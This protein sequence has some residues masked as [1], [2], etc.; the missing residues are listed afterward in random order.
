MKKSILVTVLCLICVP[1]IKSQHT[2][3][4]VRWDFPVKFGTEEWNRLENIRELIDV[5][6]IPEAV[7]TVLSTEELAEICLRYPLLRFITYSNNYDESIENLLSQFNGARELF[8][9]NDA[10]N[11]LL[12][13]YQAKMHDLS[14]LKDMPLG[15]ER[16]FFVADIAAHEL[17]ISHCLFPEDQSQD[18]YRE[19]MQQLV[20]GYEE[21][22]RYSEAFEGEFNVNLFARIKILVKADPQ[23]LELIP[24]HENNAVFWKGVTDK[25]TEQIINKLTY[26]FILPQ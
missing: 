24:Q 21:K 15:V 1:I 14:F 2:D 17:L 26:R 16:G 7:L 8:K 5:C 25:Q 4:S 9:R 19:I 6:Q 10:S 12:K 20:S 13:P 22:L 23:I 3:E 18:G 11:A